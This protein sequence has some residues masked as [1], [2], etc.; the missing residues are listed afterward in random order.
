[1]KRVVLSCALAALAHAQVALPDG[2]RV[3]TTSARWRQLRAQGLNPVAELSLAIDISDAL[4]PPQAKP[5]ASIPN[6]APTA[7]PSVAATTAPVAVSTAN[8]ASSERDSLLRLLLPDSIVLPSLNLRGTELRDVLSALGLQYGLNLL[9]DPSV[10]G[11]V[12]LN[13]LK[14]RLRDA[15]DLLAQEN[16]LLLDPLPGALKIWRPPPPPAP[17]PPEPRCSVD[18][19]DGNLS[20]DVQGASI[21]RFARVVSESTQVNVTV[22]KGVTGVVN[23]FLQKVPLAKALGLVADNTGLQLRSVSGVYSFAAAP[24]KPGDQ[25][26]ATGFGSRIAV[27]SDSLVTL[28]ANQTPLKDL[29]PALGAKVGVNLVL[30]GTP[31]GAA[32]LRV[33]KVRLTQALDYLLS[34]TDY[35]WWKR[36]DTW[37]VGPVGGAG[38]TNTDLVVLK[39]MKAEDVL[40]IVPPSVVRNAQ[41]KLVKSHNGIMVMG[42]REA[43]DG[44]RQF[45]ESVDFPVPQI[46]IEALVVDVNMDKV[47][48]IGAKA[49]L[50]SA[51]K[52]SN[53]RNIYPSFEQIFDQNDGNAVLAAMG[54]LKD[55][56]SLPKDFFVKISAMEQEKILEIRSRPQIAT[57][58]G[59]EATINIGQTQYFL[60]K[61]ETDLP[62][63]TGG[64]TVQTTQRFE[65]IEANVTLTVTPFVTGKGEITCDI[66]PDFSE[67]EGSFD[68][69][70]PPTINHRRLKSKIRLRQGETIVLGGLIKE[71][72]NK[73]HDQ[74]PILG[75]IPV[76]GWLFKNRTTTRS[77]S[78][79]L[80]FVT[81][82]IYYGSDANVDPS[83][84]LRELGK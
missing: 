38:V 67:P 33:S 4:Y 17:P 60:L 66:V 36:E 20:L 53:S 62:Q 15:L 44:I 3:D 1:M 69:N 31:T 46:L 26:G 68:A 79:L 61:S 82:H 7:E 65:K 51:G 5:A 70:T 2:R 9:V 23:L 48:N 58:N 57:L 29:I 76:L 64:T 16:G 54:G 59:S 72:N 45:V 42:S 83:K 52:G 71:S 28:E 50:G 73:V 34:G 14:I 47:R 63:S 75:S 22:E 6:P 13:L 8:S 21:E 19:S 30:I 25:A 11:S 55:V 37:F 40:E 12:T 35:T 84:V 56:V 39:H 32:T 80:I 41:L 49:F 74:V 18:W 78:Q 10:T 81:P 24:W 77:R 27:E 43:I